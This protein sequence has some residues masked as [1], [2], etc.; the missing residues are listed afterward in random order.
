MSTGEAGI[1]LRRC[2]GSLFGA[3]AETLVEENTPQEDRAHGEG[4]EGARDRAEPREV[5]EEKLRE[6]D[7]EERQPADAER[8]AAP[9]E[10]GVEEREPERAP[11]GADGGVA[12]LEVGRDVARPDPLGD[13]EDAQ[14]H[15]GERE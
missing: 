8:R 4:T 3:R 11:Q 1:R 5:V 2:G 6:A 14:R 10:P 13:L 15:A 7:A 12:A 9:A